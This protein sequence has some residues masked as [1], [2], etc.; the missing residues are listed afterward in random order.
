M[1]SNGDKKIT[2]ESNEKRRKIDIDILDEVVFTYNIN[3]HSYTNKKLFNM[4][5]DRN[6][7]NDILYRKEDN[8]NEKNIICTNKNYLNKISKIN[9]MKNQVIKVNDFIILKNDYDNNIKTKKK[10]FETFSSGPYKVIEKINSYKYVILVDNK[11]KRVKISQIQ[12]INV[13]DK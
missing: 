7:T 10:N 1:Q 4:M 13:I 2:K 3:I 8:R 5:F 12:K 9:M 11:Q 6:A